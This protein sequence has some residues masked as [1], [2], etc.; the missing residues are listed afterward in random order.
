MLKFFRKIRQKL[1][2]GNKEE[3]YLKYAIGEIIFIIFGY[4]PA[5]DLIWVKQ[6]ISQTA[7]VPLGTVR[8]I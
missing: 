8:D 7:T 5:K 1:F 2:D 4:S 3:N 6:A